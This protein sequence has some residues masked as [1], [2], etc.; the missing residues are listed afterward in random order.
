MA[1]EYINTLQGDILNSYETAALSNLGQRMGAK[2]DSIKVK[3]IGLSNIF[4]FKNYK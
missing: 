3:S 2:G 4:T 1:I